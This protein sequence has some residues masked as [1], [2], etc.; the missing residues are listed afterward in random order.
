MNKI[1]F[2]AIILVRNELAHE[3]CKNID[4]ARSN[5]ENRLSEVSVAW[6]DF[7]HE[8]L[9]ETDGK[10][11]LDKGNDGSLEFLKQMQE[12]MR[13]FCKKDSVELRRAFNIWY[14]MDNGEFE[15]L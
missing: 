10:A 4:K 7:V 13:A 12:Q 2:I 3:L 1:E 6:Y 14:A 8:V 9:Y 15:D 11:S 5:Q